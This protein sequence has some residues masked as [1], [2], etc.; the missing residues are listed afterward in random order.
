MSE[1]TEYKK[2]ELKDMQDFM[3]KENC[4]K[5]MN[6]EDVKDLLKE[7]QS[8]LKPEELKPAPTPDTTGGRRRRRRSSKKRKASKK[9]RK[10]R[11]RR[12]SRK[13]RK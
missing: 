3:D 2:E 10:S 13:G 4:A 7:K 5:I 9:A 11:R 12:S 8:E 6:I 1:N